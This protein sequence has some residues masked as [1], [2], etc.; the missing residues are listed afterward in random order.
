MLIRSF[1]NATRLFG[2]QAKRV[3]DPLQKGRRIRSNRRYNN[4]YVVNLVWEV[5]AG[6]TMMIKDKLGG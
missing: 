2:V 1:K 4:V 6:K 3:Y 5:E